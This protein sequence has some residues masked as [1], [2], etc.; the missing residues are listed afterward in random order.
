MLKRAHAAW[1]G[2][3]TRADSARLAGMLVGRPNLLF[4]PQL[5]DLD[6]RER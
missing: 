5:S 2:S 6:A 1:P 4:R 3:A